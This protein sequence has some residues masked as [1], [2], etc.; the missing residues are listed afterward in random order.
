MEEGKKTLRALAPDWEI[1]YGDEKSLCEDIQKADAVFGNPTPDLLRQCRNLKWIQTASAGVDPYLK[2]N[3][4]PEGCLL[5]NATGGYGLAISEHLL[6]MYLELIK[7]LHL[8]RDNQALAKW[9]DQGPVTSVYG[10]TVLI[11]GMG[12]IG[13]AFARLCKAMGATVIGLRR[14]DLTPSP[15]ADEIHLTDELD[16]LLP[17]ADAVAIALPGTKE[18]YRLLNRERIQR[19]KDGAIL[20]NVGRGSVVDTEALCDALESGKL[21][22]A[23]LDV[24]DPEPLPPEHRIWKLPTA[25]ITPHVSG[26]YHLSAT[27]ER[28]FGIFA[29]NFS[30]FLKGE[31][32]RNLID[33]DTG[34]RKL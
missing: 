9:E 14:T 12:D 23:G 19:M 16:S 1:L 27:R 7:K 30:A 13:T 2:E 31:K 34:Y 32:L 22:G 21:S 24:T 5:T 26:G 33:F 20:L 28:I 18:T 4:L 3:C 17:R 29:E 6:G 8:Y 10:S 11:L 25:V 15:Y